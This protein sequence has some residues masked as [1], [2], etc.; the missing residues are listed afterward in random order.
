[1]G[2]EEINMNTVASIIRG[3]SIRDGEKQALLDLYNYPQ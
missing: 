3:S 1:M 2:N